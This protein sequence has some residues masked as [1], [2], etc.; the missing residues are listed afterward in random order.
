M[1]EPHHCSRSC[2]NRT[3]GS[4][5]KFCECISFCN[6]PP[7]CLVYVC[8]LW[9]LHKSCRSVMCHF[10]SS[11][12]LLHQLFQPLSIC[13]LPTYQQWSITKNKNSHLPLN[14]GIL[15]TDCRC[16]WTASSWPLLFEPSSYL[17]W[18]ATI[19]LSDCH[20]IHRLQLHNMHCIQSTVIIELSSSSEDLP[21]W[22][23][24][25]HFIIVLVRHYG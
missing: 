3:A 21:S 18:L 14:R 17:I 13:T 15:I 2:F 4:V 19:W 25:T 5:P 20:S 16:K 8:V 22:L 11:F 7:L 24:Q 10:G 9:G 12:W 23:I 6:R 1:Q